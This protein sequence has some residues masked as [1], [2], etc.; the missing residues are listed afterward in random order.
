MIRANYKYRSFFFSFIFFLKVLIIYFRNY[1]LLEA[2]REMARRK[3][4]SRLELEARRLK[5]GEKRPLSPETNQ[6]P[7]IVEL[8]DESPSPVQSD[9]GRSKSVE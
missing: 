6:D 3:E 5:R 1:R 9:E 4:V 2:D 7:S 8:S